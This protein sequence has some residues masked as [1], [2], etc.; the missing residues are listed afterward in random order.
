MI[1]VGFFLQKFSYSIKIYNPIRRSQFTR[2]DLHDVS[3]RFTNIGAL[4]SAL[5]HEL[6][7]EISDNDE[8]SLGYFEG[9]QQKKKWLVSSSDIDAMYGYFE[10]K[11]RISLW[12]DDKQPP[13]SEYDDEKGRSK[14][15]KRRKSS[16]TQ[17]KT[18][19]DEREEEL[20]SIFQQLKERH[21]SKFSGPQLRLWA[22]MIVAKTHEDMDEPP[23]VPMITGATKISQPK[24]S[25]TDAFVSAATAIAKVLSPSQA[26][27]SSADSQK[28]PL[29]PGKK[30]DLR[31]K[32]LEQLRQLQKL[33]EDGILSQE[34]FDSQKKIVVLS[35]N[36]LA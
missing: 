15:K 35:L 34:E 29:S 23:K 3:H 16:K 8:Y 13:E 25:L 14:R 10:G 4:R 33:F 1:C 11:P 27:V 20:E 18:K 36:H 2:R 19:L 12:C 28:V 31:M 26:S 5:Y 9:K 24:E 7:D 17:R 32:N 30:L 21:E 6:E 22:R